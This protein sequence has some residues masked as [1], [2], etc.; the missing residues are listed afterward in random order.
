MQLT[1]DVEWEDV[2]SLFIFSAGGSHTGDKYIKCKVEI[3][4][5]EDWTLIGE[6]DVGTLT[7]G[8]CN[9]LFYENSTNVKN[10]YIRLTF[11]QNT[12]KAIYLNGISV[13]T[14]ATVVPAY[15]IYTDGEWYTLNTTPEETIEAK[16]PADI[17]QTYTVDQSGDTSYT[18]GEIHLV[19]KDGQQIGTN[20]VVK[21]A[22][23]AG[24]TLYAKS[25]QYDVEGDS[26][27]E[28]YATDLGLNND[29]DLI[30]YNKYGSQLASIDLSGISGGLIDLGEIDL[31]DYDY[32][33]N[34]FL[35][36]V[37]QTGRYKFTDADDGFEWYLNVINL[38]TAVQQIWWSSEEGAASI[39]LLA[40]NYNSVS[41]IIDYYVD[42]SIV[43]VEI[44]DGRY[45]SKNH[46]HYTQQTIN[47]SIRDYLTNN[48]T[49]NGEFRF[50]CS[51]DGHFY[52]A[53]CYSITYNPGT[54]SVTGK[55]Q[56]YFDLSQPWKTYSRYGT[57]S[58]GTTTWGSWHVV[59]GVS[60]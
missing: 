60:E 23:T 15:K 46:V 48:P 17:A 14:V 18:G 40:G 49:L 4:D 55:A 38:G 28:T 35:A 7:N 51:Y 43:T 2:E 53:N 27:L 42:T 26:F 36:T 12:N 52:I 44:G 57:V 22:A 45:A 9:Q 39:Y 29:T 21:W 47:V 16:I 32:D 13:N 6:Q 34:E 56:T 33:V 20:Q 25:A 41:H 50:N 11:T 8:Y 30:L 59:E 5:G 19:N 3:G 31:A 54:G 37:T 1:S 24:N 58:G 10:G